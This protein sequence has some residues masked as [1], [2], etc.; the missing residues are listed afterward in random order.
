MTRDERRLARNRATN[1]IGRLRR[2]AKAIN[3]KIVTLEL[4]VASI[5]EAG[6]GQTVM[7]GDVDLL[8]A[9][10]PA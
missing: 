9:G 7:F 4:R 10:D 8:T 6:D 3:R 5:D 2:D 1:E